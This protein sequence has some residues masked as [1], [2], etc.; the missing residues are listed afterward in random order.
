[1]MKKILQPLKHLF[2]VLRAEEDI[3]KGFSKCVQDD[4]ISLYEFPAS[5]GKDLKSISAH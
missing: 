4:D 1:M 3:L 5:G 2:T